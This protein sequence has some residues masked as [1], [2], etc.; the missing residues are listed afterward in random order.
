[1]IT[2]SIN[3]LN[4]G[5]H[6]SLLDGIFKEGS[7]WKHFISSSFHRS[8]IQEITDHLQVKIW[9]NDP[10]KTNYVS[11]ADAL[12]HRY[13]SDPFATK[14][15]QIFDRQIAPFRKDFQYLHPDNQ[16]AFSKWINASQPDEIF[17]RF[18]R[19]ADFLESS[20]LLSQIKITRDAVRL[21]DDIPA[22]LIEGN[23]VQE[24]DIYKRFEVVFSKSFNSTFVVEKETREVFTYLDN[25]KGLQK[26]HP[27]FS[28][29]TPI[30]NLNDADFEK[31][32][33]IA[34]EFIRP[35]ERDLSPEERAQKNKDR[36]FIIQ[37]VSSHNQLGDSHFDR[38]VRNPQH[39]FLRLIAGIDNPDYGIKK[40]EVYE[41]GYS[42]KETPRIPFITMKG[43]FRS[44]DFFE[45]K[46]CEKR[47][48]TNIAITPEEA[49]SFQQFILK[50][51]RDAVNLGIE[52][53]FNLTR[54]NCSVFS[55]EACKAAGIE[56]PT[57]IKLKDAIERVMPDKIKE[58]G[59][60][61]KLWGQSA[62]LWISKAAD[63]FIPEGVMNS[64][65][66][67]SEIASAM[68]SKIKDIFI[69]FILTPL[70]AFLGGVSGKGGAE[71]LQTDLSPEQ[72][73]SEAIDWNI[74]FDLTQYKIN[75]PG[76]AQ[77]WQLKQPSTVIY[78][79]SPVRLAI[80]PPS[81]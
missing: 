72:K 54:Q 55:R 22:L 35:E 1:M 64:L 69:G 21:I 59:R 74:C 28:T 18:P 46:S 51:Q 29:Q 26:H 11:L 4:N 13:K 15:V 2:R 25:G 36:T 9:G 71:F 6:L 8:E 27:F 44:P 68:L 3:L 77:E 14:I 31:T 43:R 78:D 37:Y 5:S 56:V 45:Y 20:H 63:R 38:L 40:G 70:N 32:L 39:P 23:W 61:I 24:P 7:K 62:V 48:V 80:V 41:I 81:A 17:Q 60:Q 30:S 42:S 76:I 10:D 73:N 47:I 57:E 67:T 79:H 49:R 75:L 66:Y 34:K 58:V 16:K 50:Y 65:S 52:P 19:F 33:K 53:G 12:I